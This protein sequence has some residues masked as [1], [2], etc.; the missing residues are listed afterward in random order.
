MFSP[1]T[2]ARNSTKCLLRW[3]MFAFAVKL[4]S[5]IDRFEYFDENE[6]AWVSTPLTSMFFVC[7][8]SFWFVHVVN[9]AF[10]N[11]FFFLNFICGKGLRVCVAFMNHFIARMSLMNR[12]Y[13]IDFELLN[14]RLCRSQ[15]SH[16]KRDLWETLAAQTKSKLSN[17]IFDN[18]FD[19]EL[20]L[21]F[22]RCS[23]FWYIL[24]LYMDVASFSFSRTLSTPC[25]KLFGL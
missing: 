12:K 18:F 7:F 14:F 20:F 21:L 4:H 6:N 15:V 3:F 9:D 22:P 13:S 11:I 1:N 25:E 5:M 8:R 17:G 23:R 10:D 24:V 2:N 16:R 19:C